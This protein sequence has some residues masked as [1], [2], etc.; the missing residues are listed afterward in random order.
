[1]TGISVPFSCMVNF[2]GAML[3]Q[4]YQ[5]LAAWAIIVK[6]NF[7]IADDSKQ[8]NDTSVNQYNVYCHGGAAGKVAT[9]ISL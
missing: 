4:V 5:A 2:G 7:W 3:W 1:M 9:N 6:V 8:H